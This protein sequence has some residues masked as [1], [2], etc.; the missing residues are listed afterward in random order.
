[1]MDIIREVYNLDNI[2]SVGVCDFAEAGP[3]LDVRAKS[4]LPR[5]C[6]SIIV[7]ALP[8]YSG[9]YPGRN[10]AR[11]AV[12]DDYHL[13][14]GGLLGEVA[15]EL[16]RR[17]PEHAFVPFIDVSPIREVKA[18]RL[19]GLGVIGLHGQLITPQWGPWVFIGCVVT[20]LRL[21]T[22]WPKGGNYA[23][24]TTESRLIDTCLECEACLSACPT[25]AL[26]RNGLRRELCR[27]GITQKKGA[28]T[29][30]E[31]EQVRAGKMVWG[32]D[33]CLEA[34]PMGKNPAI[35]PLE[36]LK[37]GPL[38]ILT[39]EN[40]G[41]ALARKAYSYRGRGVLERNL[42]LLGG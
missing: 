41:Q 32:C 30:W 35:T 36:C 33:I 22:Q 7:C 16:G 2:T 28:L 8:Y 9:D 23:L 38:P 12:C 5:D 1:M 15:G 42:E 19:A 6:A 24:C 39:R 31:E 3:L 20:D 14:C 10:V 34:C 4:R 21:A 18:A 40:L 13:T 26:S 17:F 11:Y 27:S 25:G 37:R 29:S